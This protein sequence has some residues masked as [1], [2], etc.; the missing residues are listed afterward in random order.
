MVKSKSAKFIIVLIF[1][2][3]FTG[4]I[5]AQ[6]AKGRTGGEGTE[7]GD[8]L[9][10]QKTEGI[11]QTTEKSDVIQGGASADQAKTSTPVQT[12]KS[13]P[14][15]ESSGTSANAGAQNNRPQTVTSPDTARG[16]EPPSEESDAV[17]QESIREIVSE[18]KDDVIFEIGNKIVSVKEDIKPHFLLA[19]CLVIVSVVFIIASIVLN[20][21]FFKKKTD[22]LQA[23]LQKISDDAQEDRNDNFL[24]LWN[25]ISNISYA[26]DNLSDKV[27]SLAKTIKAETPKP[28]PREPV[29]PKP[30]LVETSD[31][32]EDFNKWA[33]DPY[34]VNLPSWFYY[35]KGDVK[36][37]EEQKLAETG[38]PAAWIC[39]R[40]GTKKYL[41]PNPCVFDGLTNISKFYKMDA[42]GLK[43]KGQNRLMVKTPCVMSDKGWIEYPGELVLL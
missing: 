21:V 24:Q 8:S 41:L 36:I 25:E 20:I 31:P 1:A 13:T 6:D 7:A 27:E 14:T 10:E 12:Q 38:E 15:S 19:L 29:A 9:S 16:D 23:M 32:I 28:Q 42:A 18:A 22:K 30:R 37:R 39:N 17:T 5:W 34:S 33:S 26:I 35:V 43:A 3:A 40:R 11:A 4:T 2:I